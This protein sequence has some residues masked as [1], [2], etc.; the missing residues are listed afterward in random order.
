[1]LGV[2]VRQFRRCPMA[3]YT[4]NPVNFLIKVSTN[5]DAACV[6]G[7]AIARER[8]VSDAETSIDVPSEYLF[9]PELG[10]LVKV[11]YAA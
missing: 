5:P 3:R 2:E 8:E 11:T 6:A 4:A 9:S 10:K 7:A 1:M